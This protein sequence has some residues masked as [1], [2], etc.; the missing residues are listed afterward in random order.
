MRLTDRR[1][2]SLST[3]QA[4]ETFLDESLSGFGVR[5]TQSGRKTFFVRYRV[6]GR[7]PRFTIG[8]YPTISLADA[9]D[10]AKAV[11][12]DVAIGNDPARART[13]HR[14]ALTFAELADEYI[15][16]HAKKKQREKTWREDE[17]CINVDLVPA[18]SHRKANDIYRPDVHK[19]L[20]AIVDRGSP[21]MANRA[22]AVASRVF[23]FGISRGYLEVNPVQHV[24]PPARE[25]A[26]E[27]VMT[28]A[29]IQSFWKA[30]NVLTPLMA[31]TFAL[32]LITAQRRIE[33]LSMRH[34][35]IDGD[36]WT[37]PAE[38]AKNRKA[39]RVPLSPQALDVLDSVRSLSGR[40]EFVFP[41]DRGGHIRADLY[42]AKQLREEARLEDWKPHDLRRTA[43]TMMTGQL[44]VLRLVVA[45]VLNHSDRGVTAIYDRASYDAEK[46]DALLAWGDRVEEIV[47]GC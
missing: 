39:H 29:E 27:R 23:N 21:T 4:Q 20:D 24:P 41:S 36:L 35:D 7:R 30:L 8:T 11:L 19:V 5:V 2:R 47:G 32:R 9:R 25:Q 16:R 22:R 34:R 44:G 3:D 17:R 15:E 18:W 12:Y 37:I 6:N 13:E 26:R 45:K 14:S 33:V 1:V 43:A 28:V 42:A 46:R 38:V 40:S 31:P 10:R